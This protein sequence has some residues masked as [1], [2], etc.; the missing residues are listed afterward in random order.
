MLG[1]M[2]WGCST[3]S[4]NCKLSAVGSSQPWGAQPWRSLFSLGFSQSCKLNDTQ[5]SSRTGF[6]AAL[7]KCACFALQRQAHLCL[8]DDCPSAVSHWY[9]CMKMRVRIAWGFLALNIKLSS[10]GALAWVVYLPCRDMIQAHDLHGSVN[11]LL[12]PINW[13]AGQSNFGRSHCCCTQSAQPIKTVLI[14]LPQ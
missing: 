3:H 2:Q 14:K 13:S 1:W 5:L 8:L 7:E 6:D 9:G 10:H 12:N 4:S 11:F